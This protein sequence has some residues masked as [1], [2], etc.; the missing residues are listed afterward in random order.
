[1]DM[2]LKFSPAK[3]QSRIVLKFLAKSFNF[4]WFLVYIQIKV[5][6][7]FTS[8]HVYNQGLIADF[9]TASFLIYLFPASLFIF[10]SSFQQIFH[11]NL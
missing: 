7:K 10:V 1:M 4:L 5:V 9:G 8:V 11:T 2:R 3:F 6:Q